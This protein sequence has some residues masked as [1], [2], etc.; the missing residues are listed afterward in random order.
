MKKVY[1]NR[2][3]PWL[4]YCCTNGLRFFITPV[5]SDTAESVLGTGDEHVLEVIS[6]HDCPNIDC[7]RSMFRGE[8]RSA[9][10]EQSYIRDLSKAEREIRD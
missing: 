5:F 9:V 6:T 2:P 4:K 3:R 1:L 8:R 10:S 7:W